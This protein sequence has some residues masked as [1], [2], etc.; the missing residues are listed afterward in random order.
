MKISRRQLK[1]I[2]ENIIKN[3]K[4]AKEISFKKIDRTIER[5]LKKEGGAAGLG[6]IVTALKKLE[7][8]QFVLPMKCSTKS[9]IKKYI[10]KSDKFIV[11]KYK[12]VILKKGLKINENTIL[13][14][15][16]QIGFY[17]KYGFGID[18][19]EKDD[20]KDYDDIIGHT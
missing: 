11:H 10:E 14:E 13:S 18:D 20:I 17:K 2:I 16:E 6:M 8:G 9:K 7:V 15:L 12:D 3:K 19:L 1:I 5:I 4:K